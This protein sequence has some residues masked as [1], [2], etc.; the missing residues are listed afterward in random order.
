[1]RL[2]HLKDKVG[3]GCDCLM[4]G[5]QEGKEVGSGEVGRGLKG[6]G[7]VLL[8]LNVSMQNFKDSLSILEKSRQ[9]DL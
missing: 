4:Q 6:G 1:M 2:V 9:D 7:C 5:E 8:S 3:V